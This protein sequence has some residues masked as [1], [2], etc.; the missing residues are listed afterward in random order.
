MNENAELFVPKGSCGA[1]KILT[2]LAGKGN[3]HSF[4]AVWKRKHLLAR[5]K[6]PLLKTSDVQQLPPPL[7]VVPF[8]TRGGFLSAA[9]RRVP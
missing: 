3:S 6:T 5:G 1:D 4:F 2:R 8:N 9:A 7:A